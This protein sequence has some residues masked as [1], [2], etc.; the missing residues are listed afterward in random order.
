[1]IPA[2]CGR[3]LDARERVEQAVSRERSR[4]L[5]LHRRRQMAQ[6]AGTGPTR[7]RLITPAWPALP[8]P[9]NVNV[10]CAALQLANVTVAVPTATLACVIGFGV[11][12]TP[13]VVS[14]NVNG[15]V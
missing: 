14:Y 9:V 8:P 7:V 6:P 3:A 13:P 12:K 15:A 2:Q 11:S 5:R 10:S 1:M 4:R